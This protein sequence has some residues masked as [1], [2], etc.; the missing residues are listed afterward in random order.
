MNKDILR[1]SD[2][3]KISSKAVRNILQSFYSTDLEKHKERIDS[4]VL[5]CLEELYSESSQSQSCD[6][7]HELDKPK[8]RIDDA[9]LRDSIEI[10]S[11][12]LD[13]DPRHYVEKPV[14]EVS[15]TDKDRLLALELQNQLGGRRTRSSG[16]R[17]AIRA[18]NKSSTKSGSSKRAGSSTFSRPVYLSDALEFVIGDREVGICFIRF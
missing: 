11:S 15:Q 14:E 17:K 4:L 18:V 1:N 13:D 9:S 12:L 7:E 10:S 8:N 6:N 5:D 2:L 3:N 16:K